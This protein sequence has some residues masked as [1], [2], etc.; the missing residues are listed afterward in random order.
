LIRDLC[1]GRINKLES[2][3]RG[4]AVFGGYEVEG[5]ENDRVGDLEIVSNYDGEWKSENSVE[6]NEVISL[7][8]S[9]SDD[10]D[11]DMEIWDDEN[12]GWCIVDC[13]DVVVHVFE[14][15]KGTREKA[16]LEKRWGKEGW[17]E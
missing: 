6:D 14:E 15:G 9:S 8:V 11:D 13:G 7:N 3:S 5:E 4:E 2:E 16:D 1:K 10:D 12:D 17:E